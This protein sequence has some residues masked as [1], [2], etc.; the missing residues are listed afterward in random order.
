MTG[1][2]WCRIP[3]VIVEMGFM[4]NPTED[5]LMQTPSYQAKMVAGLAN[6]VDSYFGK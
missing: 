4:T 5:V 6:G 1:I 2:N 3:V